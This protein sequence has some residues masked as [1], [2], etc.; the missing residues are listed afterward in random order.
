[1]AEWVLVCVARDDHEPFVLAVCGG[2]QR[3]LV[4]CRCLGSSCGGAWAP[5]DAS[6]VDAP[7]WQFLFFGFFLFKF[8]CIGS[9]LCAY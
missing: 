1:V 8:G 4:N 7:G 6:G 5:R 3:F 2:D 9:L